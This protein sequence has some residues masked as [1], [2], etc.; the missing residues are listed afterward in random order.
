MSSICCFEEINL[1]KLLCPYKYTEDKKNHSINIYKKSDYIYFEED[2]ANKI[3][4]IE[5]GKVKIGYFTEDGEEQI[6]AILAKGEIFGEKAILGIENH[7][8]FAQSIEN[9]TSVCVVSKD[10]VHSL[11]KDN[12]AIN[13]KIHKII[14]Q[15]VKRLENRLKLLLCKDAKM[16]LIEFFNELCSDYGNLCNTTQDYIIQHPYTQKDI[17][18]LIGISRPTL[19]TLMNQMKQE[20]LIDFNRKNL[21]LFKKNKL[22]VSYLTF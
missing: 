19:N 22:N 15:R 2:P 13:F 17:A 18:T 4:L 3:Y 20:G 1:F 21:R 12:S 7:N 10:I 14:G 5:F 9:S 6:K 11:M 8:E 16:R